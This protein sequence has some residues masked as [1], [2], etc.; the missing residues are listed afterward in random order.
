M[1]SRDDRRFGLRTRAL[2]AGTSPDPATGARAQPVY[3]SSSFVFDSTEHA[4]EL[5]ALRTYGNIYSRIGNP[6]V[7]AFEE[8]V[9]S[10]EGALGGVATASGLAAQLTAILALAQAGDHFVASASLYGGTVTQ[11]S[12]TLK[13]MGIDVAFVPPNDFDAT[14][15]AIREDTRFVYTETIG[16]PLGVVADLEAYANVAHERGLPLMVDNTFASPVLCRPIEWGADIIVE[17]GT[18]PWGAGK[19]PLLS[20]PS[21]GYH[22]MNFAETFGEYAYLMRVRTEVLRDVGGSLSP[23]SAFLFIQGVETL[24]LRMPAHVANAQA[25]ARF[26][27]ERPEVA[28]VNYAGLPSDPSHAL[29]Q[30]YLPDGPG[31][32]FTFGLRGGYEA[33]RAFIEG[34]ELWSHLANV[35]D[36]K[37][38]VIHPASTTH[39]QLSEADLRAGGISPEMVRLSVGLEDIEDLLWDLDR[40]LRMTGR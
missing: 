1:E 3:L 31:S 14:R 5:F 28:W 22:D 6:T 21:P 11:F 30:K 27:Q 35:G 38:L 19:H 15:A 34:L 7:A 13:R 2:H 24:G 9:A 18:F 8:K 25:V 10:L 20:T 37:S 33:G 4:A 40:A 29:A 16:N 23:M 12:V 17:S 36:A 39:Q 32:V 26:L